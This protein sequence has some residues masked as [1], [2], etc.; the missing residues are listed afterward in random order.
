MT[1]KQFVRKRLQEMHDRPGMWASTQEAFGLQLALLVEVYELDIE[2]SSKMPQHVI[3]QRIF[4][5]G[6][7]VSVEPLEESW[8]Q[9]TAAMIMAMIK[10]ELA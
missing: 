9:S 2:P 10:V 7:S 4:G 6:N 3:M 1:N 8:A 5:P